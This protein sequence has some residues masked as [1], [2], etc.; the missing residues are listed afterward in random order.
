MESAWPTVY[1]KESRDEWHDPMA[2]LDGF[3][4]ILGR[5]GK[6]M[7]FWLANRP[8]FAPAHLSIDKHV[9]DD[10]KTCCS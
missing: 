1:M 7:G 6:P 5:Y 9:A 10:S 8:N 4:E 2:W 3:G